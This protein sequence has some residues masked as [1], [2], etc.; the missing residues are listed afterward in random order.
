MTK[1]NV[2]YYCMEAMTLD[3]INGYWEINLWLIIILYMILKIKEWELL[4]AQIIVF[5]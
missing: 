1:I 5:E 4:K 3:M 2:N